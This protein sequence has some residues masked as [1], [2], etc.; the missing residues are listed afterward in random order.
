VPAWCSRYLEHSSHSKLTLYSLSVVI[1]EINTKHKSISI[2]TIAKCPKDLSKTL[3][4]VKAS[5]LTGVPRLL[6][7]AKKISRHQY[8]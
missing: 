1:I 5:K 4:L 7:I 3:L 8:S 6:A 2:R